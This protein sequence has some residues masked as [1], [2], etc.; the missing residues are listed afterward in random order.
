[1]SIL[2]ID[3]IMNKVDQSVERFGV[4]ETIKEFFVKHVTNTSMPVL[5]IDPDNEMDL[6]KFMDVMGDG[7]RY[8]DMRSYKN[9]PYNSF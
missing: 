6:E 9:I 4:L 3:G 7:V 5:L 1:M 8:V 2:D